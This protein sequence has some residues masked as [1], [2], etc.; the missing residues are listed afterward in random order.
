M[1]LNELRDA[2]IQMV[3]EHIG[4]ND[5][6]VSASI[7]NRIEVNGRENTGCIIAIYPDSSCQHVYFVTGVETPEAALEKLKRQLPNTADLLALGM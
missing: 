3:H 1:T 5:L 4:A 2:A 6:R 7:E